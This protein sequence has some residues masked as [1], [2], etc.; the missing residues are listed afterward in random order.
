M[1]E[2][3][4][5]PILIT[6]ENLEKYGFSCFYYEEEKPTEDF[7]ISEVVMDVGGK[8]GD[9]K[10]EFKIPKGLYIQLS[11][12]NKITS[13]QRF[14]I[15][16][17]IE[18]FTAIKLLTER[19]GWNQT[20]NDL[21]V[22]IAGGPENIFLATYKY[23]NQQIVL[24]SGVSLAVNENMC[25]IGMILVHQELRRQ[26]IARAIMQSCIKHARIDQGKSIIGLDAT[27][28]GKQVYDALGFKD[29]FTIWRS[30][31]SSH[32][33][34]DRLSTNTPTPFDLEMV[35]CYLKMKDY[36][37]KVQII[38]MLE[39]VPGAE[40]IILLRDGKVLG[41]AMSRPG[42]LKP[43]IGPLIADT[44]EI[45][46]D[47]LLEALTYWR[48]SGYEEVLMDIPDLHFGTGAL[49][50]SMKVI[51]NAGLQQIPV[52]PVR[53]FMRMY[54]LISVRESDAFQL[55]HSSRQHAV[56]SYQ[57]TLD[58]M[59]KE[60]HKIVPIMFGTAGPEWS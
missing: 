2:D 31:I 51:S 46:N 56:K 5:N 27:P 30:V 49:F 11:P 17:S 38:E 9:V 48:K 54:Q 40:N 1:S 39:K 10:Q 28:D 23:E 4:E 18:A 12:K 42:R 50:V 34:K 58:F 16:Q 6:K 53:S 45:A 41:F 29:S 35:A 26:G 13:D 25:W 20:D 8:P 59:N 43:F 24:G 15:R 57:L 14:M 32:L 37:E 55:D 60:K 19:A 47:L 52:H 3:Q 44:P 36:S 21:K 22:M 7:I 33:K